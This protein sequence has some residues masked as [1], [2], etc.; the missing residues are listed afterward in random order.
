MKQILTY[1]FVFTSNDDSLFRLCL[2]YKI[3]FYL[4]S[5]HTGE[6]L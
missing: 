4:L 1:S 3:V 2:G 5:F 6:M